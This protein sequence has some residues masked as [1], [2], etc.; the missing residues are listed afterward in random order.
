[1]SLPACQQRILDRIDGTLQVRDPR[2]ASMFW[3]FTRLTRHEPMPRAEE[4]DG[5]RMRWAVQR[6]R[7]ACARRPRLRAFV[8]VPLILAAFAGLLILSPLTGSTR[9]CGALMLMQARGSAQLAGRASAC[10]AARPGSSGVI[11]GVP[12]H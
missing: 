8:V 11:A 6:F 1:M 3:I 12:L 10:E 2:L 5:R 7:R 4:L 9:P